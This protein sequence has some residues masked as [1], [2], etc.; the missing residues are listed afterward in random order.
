MKRALRVAS[1]LL[2]AAGSVPGS[3][4]AAPSPDTVKLASHLTLL[5]GL[6]R[7]SPEEYSDL[8]KE[9]LAWLD[10]RIRSGWNA[11]ELNW[12]L[13]NAGLV[14][15]PGEK[16]EEQPLR[17]APDLLALTVAID[18]RESGSCGRNITVVLYDR[19][20]LRRIA[21]IDP[22]TEP[23]TRGYHLLSI[24]AGERDYTDED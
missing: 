4:S 12:D 9:Y 21:E 22:G 3:L 20:T 16:S 5:R 23:E 24:D 18:P 7:L 2:V 1:L 6:A 8:R 17:H 15:P 19:N 13:A 11:N 14:L 10:I